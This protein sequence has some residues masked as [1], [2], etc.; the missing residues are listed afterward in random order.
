M[1]KFKWKNLKLSKKLFLVV[2]GLVI[3]TFVISIGLFKSYH[4]VNKNVRLSPNASNEVGE[5]Q[6]AWTN[7]KIN[8]AGHV[9]ENDSS[10][11]IMDAV[12]NKVY[13]ASS[14]TG[15]GGHATYQLV[16]NMG[17]SKNAPAG[18][19]TIKI[20]RYLYYGRDGKPLTDQVI[21]IPL[22]E[23]PN[24]GGTG[25][26]WRYEKDDDGNDWIVLENNQEIS[27][28][29][30]FECS[31]TWIL[32]TPSELADGYTKEI[33]G[34]V[35]IDFEQDG[36]IDILANSN[37]LN[38]ENHS[39]A[40]IYSLYERTSQHRDPE[41]ATY[42]NLYSNWNNNWSDSIKPENASDYVYAIWNSNTEVRYATQ[43]YEL[44]FKSEV[45]DD[46]GGEIIGYCRYSSY[47]ISSST[48]NSY[49]NNCF[50]KT[51]TGNSTT[52]SYAYS[53]NGGS[54]YGD[55]SHKASTQPLTASITRPLEEYEQYYFYYYMVKYPKDVLQDGETHTLKNKSIVELTGVDGA[56]DVKE[57]T[58]SIDYK[59]VY[60]EPTDVWVDYPG[61]V[62]TRYG[63]LYDDIFQ[64][65]YWSTSAL[66]G[67][68]SNVSCLYHDTY[69]LMRGGLN[70][71][72]NSD[73]DYKVRLGGN[74]YSYRNW[75]N[76]GS[77]QGYNLTYGGTGSNADLDNYGVKKYKV[78]LVN[79]DFLASNAD[80]DYVK[81]GYGD[82]ELTSFY[83]DSFYQYDY[84]F[85]EWTSYNESTK[86]TTHYSGYREA[87]NNDYSSYPEIDIYYKTNGD[88][89]K[90]GIIKT[91]A[92]NTYKF[93]DNDG[94]EKAINS[95]NLVDLPA[96]TT[97]IKASYDTNR[98]RT[99]LYLY[100]KAKLINSDKVQSIYEDSDTLRIY[101]VNTMYAEQDGNIYTDD[102]YGYGLRSN[103]S[104]IIHD[105]D[106][107]RYGLDD[108]AHEYDY[109]DYSRISGGTTYQSK[110][111][112][113][114]NDVLNRRVVAN[115][116][117][118]AYEYLNFDSDVLTGDDIY[119]YKIINEQKVGTFYD[120]LPIGV[121]ADLSTVKVTGYINGKNI[122]VT[123][124]VKSNWKGTGRDMLIVKAKVD[125]NET[126]RYSSYQETYSGMRLTFKAYY[127]W[128]SIADYGSYLVNTVAYKSGSGSLSN[129]YP[130]DSSSISTSTIADKDY[131]SDLDEDGNPEGTIKDTV[132]AQTGLSFAFNTASDASFRKEVKTANMT[133]FVDG[134][135]GD[136]V[137]NAGGYY[138][139][140]L[141]YQSQKNMKST[142]LVIYDQLET[143]DDG[144]PSWKGKL[145]DINL[146]QPKSK[147]IEPVVYYTTKTDLN[148]Y[149]KGKAIADEDPPSVTDISD[150]SI[151]ST[152]PP[153]DMSSVT[154]IAI[155]LSKDK[156]GND[157]TLKSEESVTITMTMQ[158]PVDN[159][160]ELEEAGATAKN[161]SWWKG[162]T[163]QGNE[164]PH[165][166]YS[167][168]EW[169]QVLLHDVPISIDKKSS[170]VSG[171]EE[172]PTMVQKGE[173]FIYDVVVKNDST[174]ESFSDV[175]VTDEVSEAVLVHPDYLA[176]YK[177]G[178]GSIN[179][180]RLLSE[181]G[182]I[183]VEFDNDNR[184][185]NFNVKQ[186]LAGEELHI[187]I[188]VTVTTSNKELITNQAQL[189][190]F[191]NVKY[192][193][194]SPKTY[195][196]SSSG[197]VSITKKV[198]ALYDLRAIDKHKEFKFKVTLALPIEDEN[199]VDED[200]PADDIEQQSNS[201]T[202]NTNTIEHYRLV[203]EIED[204][205]LLNT[206]Y[207]DV[208]FVD[209]VGVF[210]LKDGETINLYNLPVG[211]K[212]TIEEE[213]YSK[214]GYETKI[215]NKTGLIEGDSHID[216]V[217]T[218]TYTRPFKNPVTGNGVKTLFVIVF[219]S[220]V[221]L[222]I[223]VRN[224]KIIR[225]FR[226]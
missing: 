70:T 180:Y 8:N 127:S 218:N 206:K 52:Y 79:E 178:E 96:G 21:D 204:L 78:N 170:K 83:I 6:L 68:C 92:S 98:Y 102:S 156:N 38:F 132:Y 119:D 147:G 176:Y 90:L 201:D 150:T 157:Y 93:I 81:L 62:P 56:T 187:L 84:T 135:Q 105:L 148:F 197:N 190:G 123:S 89:K 91:T 209:G 126:N 161:A 118:Y 211:M 152:E 208:E 107:E 216:V 139:Y 224:K 199:V 36:L 144:T 82:Y 214:D 30:L 177:A 13:D 53:S 131:M 43:P 121:S 225:K 3:I 175:L 10:R 164:A 51:S 136:V 31:I 76:Y 77:F 125:E 153:E 14:N 15:G 73:S 116:T 71:L 151:W 158:A 48:T 155:D 167:V 59:Y 35:S 87:S 55:S 120:L 168:Y 33:Q 11:F 46:L 4:K 188:P 49:D 141:R 16:L 185:M 19:I 28:S 217:V 72:S 130:D 133:D 194:W 75:S 34:E 67:R 9:D 219:L 149:E 29:Y 222:G 160:K 111:V 114:S 221:I 94:N 61:V 184:K 124:S 106:Q 174:F 165:F 64:A 20:P 42:V 32:I 202:E 128:D 169:T 58:S 66:S 183:D 186:L 172:N 193:L 47:G 74:Y 171:T 113:Y 198:D 110:S 17:G 196:V 99:F 39:H 181:D 69:G 100:F 65:T 159:A 189:R 137:A 226:K 179:E 220:I 44:K 86:V 200:I 12:Q 24:E 63:T 57:A 192:E 207:G 103:F 213:D 26:N 101:N 80:T 191:N 2:F 108:V 205:D 212:Y 134:Q 138:T 143:Y 1:K 5:F 60:I 223:S 97:G 54:Y 45:I 195:H 25:F 88:W 18:S 27:A 95:S 129:G 37:K 40:S 142:G 104:Q 215:S 162:T 154:A 146:V 85:Q 22:V 109:M 166:S 7:S 122:P 182:A 50:S 163:Q 115:Y 145:I 140:Q 210:S 112:T 173:K 41:S 117:A 203:D 23:Y